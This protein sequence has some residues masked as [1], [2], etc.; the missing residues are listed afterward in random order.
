M[1]ISV[2]KWSEGLNNKVCIIIKR[3]VDQAKFA[4]CMDIS[5]VTFFR[6]L[7]VP[8]CINGY[9]LIVFIPLCF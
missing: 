1:L 6:I 2:E 9:I 7:L 4:A 5:F 3:Y 8:F